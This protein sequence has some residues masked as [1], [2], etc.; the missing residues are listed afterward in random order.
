LLL[1][2]LAAVPLHQELRPQ[3]LRVLANLDAEDARLVYDAIRLAQPGGLGAVDAEDVR[4]QPTRPM[5]EIMALAQER[6]LIAR[7][8]VDGFR[9]VLDDGVPALQ[10]RLRAGLCL[11]DAIIAVHLERMADHPDSLI[12][13]KRGPE[14][15]AEAGR[16]AAA[17]LALD[18]PHGEV[19]RRAFADLDAWLRAEG[20]TRNPGT[21]AD[22]V[23]ASLFVA[24]RARIIPLP[25]DRPWSAD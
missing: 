6:D 24:L 10:R 22:L 25:L 19:S 2:P 5:G 15:A 7:Q 11:E 23:T 18:W 4:Q 16:R 14:E 17:V 1:A 8:Y 21:S 3:L 9:A 20:H 12:A 13:R